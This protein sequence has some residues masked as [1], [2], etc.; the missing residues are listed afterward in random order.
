MMKATGFGGSLWGEGV[1]DDMA[2]AAPRRGEP[3]GRAKAGALLRALLARQHPGAKA[4]A[5][6]KHAVSTSS[7]SI[8]TFIEVIVLIDVV[9]LICLWRGGGQFSA[10]GWHLGTHICPVVLST[11]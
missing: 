8:A 11:F 4:A 9:I 2:M 1:T 7:D 5:L 3:Q 10:G 6:R